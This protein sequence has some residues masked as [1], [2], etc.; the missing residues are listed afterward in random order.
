MLDDGLDSLDGV[1]QYIIT[2]GSW[3]SKQGHDVHYLVGQTSRTDINNVHSLS[4]N[5]AVRFNGNKMTMPLPGSSKAIKQFL[6]AEAF[7]VLHVQMPYSPFLAGKIIKQAPSKTVLVGTFHILPY[8]RLQAWGARGLAW[9]TARSTK[10]LQQIWSVSEPAQSF[11]HKLGIESSVLPNVVDTKQFKNHDVKPV[12][13]G[14]KIVFLGR[15][16][17]RKGCLELLKAVAELRCQ[18]VDVNVV[19][20]GKGPQADSL[21]HWVGQHGLDDVVAFNGFVEEA[22]KPALL[23]SANLAIFPSLG[24]ESFGIVLIEA[25]AA[26]AEVVLGGDNPGYSSVLGSLPESL[27]TAHDPHKLA[28]QIGHILND[29]Q[30]RQNLH[31][32]QKRLVEQYDVAVVGQKLLSY[33]Q[34]LKQKG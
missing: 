5:M 31:R 21:Q 29:P 30:Q 8:R 28:S 17:E 4:R 33:Y 27:V 16:V 7:D 13:G 22:D 2:L 32:K 24:G 25:M 19:I 23:A 34:E 9:W 14:S 12:D 11:A 20:G 18:Q 3:F 15:L 26:G 1:Q 6:A 10:R